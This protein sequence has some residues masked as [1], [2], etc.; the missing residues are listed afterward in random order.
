MGPSALSY[1]RHVALKSVFRE[2]GTYND[3]YRRSYSASGVDGHLAS[4]FR[5]MV[6]GVNDMANGFNVDMMSSVSNRLLRPQAQINPGVDLGSI[7]NGWGT[8][9]LLFTI[10]VSTDTTGN[11]NIQPERILINGYS[12][13]TGATMSGNMDPNMRIYFNS[14]VLLRTV[15]QHGYAWG[16]QSTVPA[17]IAHVIHMV[18]DPNAD[19]YGGQTFRNPYTLLRPYDVV[20]SMDNNFI[21]PGS[22]FD[23]TDV[24]ASPTNAPLMSSRNNAIATKYLERTFQSLLKGY[25]DPTVG[26]DQ[27]TH[28]T[29][30]ADHLRESYTTKLSLFQD[31]AANTSYNQLGF[32]TYGEMCKLIPNL[33]QITVLCLAGKA[34]PTTATSYFGTPERGMVNG[35]NGSDQETMIATVMGSAIPALMMECL[36]N[37][38]TMTITNRTLDRD[39]SVVIQNVTMFSESIEASAYVPLFVSR[40]KREILADITQGNTL[41]VSFNIAASTIEDTWLQISFM[42]GPVTDYVVPSFSDALISPI[43]GTNPQSL[44]SLAFSIDGLFN[45]SMSVLDPNRSQNPSSAGLLKIPVNGSIF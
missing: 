41:D 26:E 43:I 19:P 18:A 9:R 10:E 28:Y 1:K 34:S 24:R 40:L 4:D 17:D 31:F 38:I 15:N 35:W 6:S 2:T 5:Q 42:G 3:I 37:T 33:D 29:S 14:V 30:A 22:A 23:V 8:R 11:S 25:R 36:I 44:H 20:N 13:Y 7:A 32:V 45:S 12:D 39:F 21:Y 16:G 27:R